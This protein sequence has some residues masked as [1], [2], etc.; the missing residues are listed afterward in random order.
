MRFA[1][2][3][4]QFTV[5][6]DQGESAGDPYVGGFVRH[7]QPAPGLAVLDVGCGPG[8]FHLALS[9][10]WIVGLDLSMGMLRE[11]RRLGTRCIQGDAQRLPFRDA[12][13]DRV[14]SNHMLFHVPDRELALREMRRVLRHGGRAVLTTNGNPFLPR[15][16]ELHTEVARAAGL[17]PQPGGVSRFTMDDL[18]LVQRVFPNAQRHVLSGALVVP[19]ADSVLRYYASSAVDRVADAPA[20]GSHRPILLN[21]MRRRLQAII[22]AEGAFKDPK[23][24]GWFTAQLE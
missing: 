19:D 13:F 12:S 9:G 11:A 4:Q 14:T 7:V 15:L 17:V 21:A 10:M 20:D 16:A 22:A 1:E 5:W 2:T 3:H 23:T 24:A 6:D 18:E 8:T